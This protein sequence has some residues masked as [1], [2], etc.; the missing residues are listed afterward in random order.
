L[1]LCN[2][3]DYVVGAGVR[4]EMRKFKKW[5][6]RAYWLVVAI[7]AVAIFTNPF[8]MGRDFWAV[9]VVFLVSLRFLAKRAP[10]PEAAN[11][12]A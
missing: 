11:V 5:A 4:I 7:I 8:G 3:A 12:P 6:L 1:R 10:K 2:C 9:L